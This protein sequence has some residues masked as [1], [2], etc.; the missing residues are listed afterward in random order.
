LYDGDAISSTVLDKPSL[1]PF[2]LNDGE[3]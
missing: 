2:Q 3:P 1:L